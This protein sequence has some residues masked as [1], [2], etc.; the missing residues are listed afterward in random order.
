MMARSAL[1]AVALAALLAASWEV[2]AQSVGTPGSGPLVPGGPRQ[3]LGPP[4]ITDSVPDLRLRS[5]GGGIP[6]A[7]APIGTGSPNSVPLYER[8]AGAGAT[9]A[10]PSSRQARGRHCETPRST[11]VLTRAASL[12]TACSCRIRGNGPRVRGTVAY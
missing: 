8:G 1:R 4:S 10:R 9:P 7:G 11:C 2:S 6:G 5:S 12:G 3:G